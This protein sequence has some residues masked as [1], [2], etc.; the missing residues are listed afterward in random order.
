MTYTVT[1]AGNTVLANRIL[2]PDGVYPQKITIQRG[3]KQLTIL[4]YTYDKDTH[5][6]MFRFD[7]SMTEATIEITFGKGQQDIGLGAMASTDETIVVNNKNLDEKYLISNTASA[8]DNLRF[9]DNN[10]QLVYRFDLTEYT[11]PIYYFHVSQNYI[12][13]IS[14]D[15]KTWTI[16]ADYSQGGTV[17]RI[18]NGSNATVITVDPADYSLDDELYV[19]FRNTQTVGGF[20]AT[21]SRITIRHLVP[22]SEVPAGD[23]A[24]GNNNTTQLKEPTLPSSVDDSKYRVSTDPNTGISKYRRRVTTNSRGE[25]E[26]FLEFTD[27]CVNNDIRYCDGAR[28]LIYC[29]D[30]SQMLT[31]TFR[32]NVFQNYIL[33]VSSDGE[34][35]TIVAD[36]SQ[37]GKI[38]HLTTGGN[39]TTI[40]VDPFEYGCEETGFLYVRLRNTDTTQGWGGS[41][42]S[43]TMEYTKMG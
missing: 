29:F 40:T 19:R 23:Q 15:N 9:C 43:F 8:S 11:D 14:A 13:E 20:G 24:K 16:I 28:Q 26:E 12:V 35:Y 21:L 17:P 42:S 10:G 2:L 27:A 30:V 7:G 31:A 18:Q 25:D 5:S 6:C 37:G 33:E 41:I 1:S 3:N 32:F 38:P 22:A 36:Y 4:E 34:D 39:N